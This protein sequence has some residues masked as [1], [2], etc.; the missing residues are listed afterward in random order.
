MRAIIVLALFISAPCFAHRLG[1]SH[2]PGCGHDHQSQGRFCV[3]EVTEGE[4]SSRELVELLDDAHHAL[5][6]HE[7]Q[8]SFFKRWREKF[9]FKPVL[10]GAYRWYLSRQGRPE[11]A[12]ASANIAA[13]LLTSHTIETIGGLSLASLGLSQESELSQVVLTTIGVSVTVP[14]LDP[15][16]LILVGAYSKWPQQ[17]NRWLTV[18]RLF[19]VHGAKAALNLAQ[20]PEGVVAAYLA[21]W[22]KDRFL[23]ALHEEGGP[24][25]LTK[26]SDE[27]ISIRIFG[28]DRD[29]H[30]DLDFVNHGQVGMS[31]E[32]VRLGPGIIYLTKPQLAQALDPLGIN[33]SE[34][35]KD[36][37]FERKGSEAYIRDITEMPDGERRVLMLPGAFP[38]YSLQREDCEGLL[39]KPSEI[40]P[41]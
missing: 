30:I 1:H 8:G 36:L 7:E 10:L 18:P 41:F 31:L 38:F 29:N 26:L 21:L 40:A 20:V 19:V 27:Q 11:I 6:G 9:R 35:L 5:E 17:M 39:M 22:G 33:I 24:L 4:V 25:R 15:L 3:E 14:G 2:G 37:V 34:I 13:M 23:R 12:N 32:E 16:C 28:D